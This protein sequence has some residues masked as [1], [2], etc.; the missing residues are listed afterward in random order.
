MTK[1]ANKLYI[2]KARAPSKILE[3]F[4]ENMHPFSRTLWDTKHLIK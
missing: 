1:L 3:S 2:M 4:Y